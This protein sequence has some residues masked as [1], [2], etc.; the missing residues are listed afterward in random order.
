MKTTLANKKIST[1]F[2]QALDM[3]EQLPESDQEALVEVIRSRLIERR[4]TEIAIHARET[5]QAFREG[6]AK[7]GTLEDLKEDLLSQP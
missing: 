2:Q 5:L 4:R 6:R 1:P 7:Y 3:V